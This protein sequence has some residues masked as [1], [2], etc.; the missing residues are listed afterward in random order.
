LPEVNRRELAEKREGRSWLARRGFC[1]IF[2]F[3]YKMAGA[4]EKQ[5]RKVLNLEQNFKDKP[6]LYHALT[7]GAISINKLARI[8]GIATAENESDLMEMAKNLPQKSLEVFVKEE[9]AARAEA[10]IGRAVTNAND[11]QKPLFDDKCV[12]AQMYETHATFETAVRQ[13]RPVELSEEVN[14]KLRELKEKG[15][16]VDALLL[17]FLAKREIE[18][19]RTKEQIAVEI[20]AK[21]AKKVAVGK[22]PAGAPAA[23]HATHASA[24][25]GAARFELSRAP[26]ASIPPAPSHTSRHIPVKVIQI[27]RREYGKK[28]SIPNCGRDAKTIH[29]TSRFAV[30]RAHDPRFMAPLCHEH[31]LLAHGADM[32]FWKKYAGC[33]GNYG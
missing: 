18:I 22:A 12:R 27:L 16:D 29:H 31:H 13:N 25:P 3:A 17:E 4:S 5:V 11:L 8:S 9:R 15:I 21:A 7:T 28:C 1:S 26:S 6:A 23:S 24:A 33:K 20:A 14:K 30:S 32:Q 10:L 2:E 19:A